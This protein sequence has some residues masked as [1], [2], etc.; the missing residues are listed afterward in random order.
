MKN[1]RRI[2][3]VETVRVLWII[4]SHKIKNSNDNI[5][6]NINISHHNNHEDQ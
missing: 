2:E 4:F 3:P 5:T 6:S 1:A